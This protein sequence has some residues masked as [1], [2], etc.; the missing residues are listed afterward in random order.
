MALSM[1]KCFIKTPAKREMNS[2]G[3]ML[4]YTLGTNH[5]EMLHRALE[6]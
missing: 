6:C 5:M 1:I 2:Y 4:R 3:F